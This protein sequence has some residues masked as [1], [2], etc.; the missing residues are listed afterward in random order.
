M[1]PYRR[2]PE[3]IY[4]NVIGCRCLT[5]GVALHSALRWDSR[6]AQVSPETRPLAVCTRQRFG[7]SYCTG[8]RSHM[9]RLEKKMINNDKTICSSK[10]FRV[11]NSNGLYGCLSDW[12]DENVTSTPTESKVEWSRGA[13]SSTALLSPSSLPQFGEAINA[14]VR[15]PQSNQSNSLKSLCE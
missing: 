1:S 6:S 15:S 5:V 13:D 2:R 9:W 4:Q 10:K 11:I 3:S 14:A 7:S 8:M 12:A